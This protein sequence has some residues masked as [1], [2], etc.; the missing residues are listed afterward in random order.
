M[1]KAEVKAASMLCW[2][3]APLICSWYLRPAHQLV[4]TAAIHADQIKHRALL[5]QLVV[6]T[7]LAS[8]VPCHKDVTLLI[9]PC[10]SHQ[11]VKQPHGLKYKVLFEH[12]SLA[13]PVLCPWAC[14]EFL[15]LSS[16][17]A[18][19]TLSPD[20]ATRAQLTVFFG[21]D[22]HRLCNLASRDD[23]LCLIF[24]FSNGSTET[25]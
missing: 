20:P 5:L 11:K 25:P 7:S 8:L 18:H 13:L 3:P 14:I 10:L 17:W 6:L 23:P 12:V 22:T 24:L 9:F 1:L 15:V 21:I 19:G 16:K 4:K 2:I